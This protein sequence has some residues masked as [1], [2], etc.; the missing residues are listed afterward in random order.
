MK[1]APYLTPTEFCSDPENVEAL[2][3]FL[4][5]APGQNLLSVLLGLN[6]A[7]QSLRSEIPNE[8]DKRAEHL[9][10]R[11]QGYEFAFETLTQTLVKRIDHL[12]PLSR[13]AGR[14]EIKPIR[15]PQP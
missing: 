1:I 9:F 14:S 3:A 15:P 6:P 7:R 4:A 10:G 13:K 2:N 5:S 12:P 11:C 8:V